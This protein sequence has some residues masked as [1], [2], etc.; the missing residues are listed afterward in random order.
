[1]PPLISLDPHQDQTSVTKCNLSTP[2]INNNQL[3]AIPGHN[4]RNNCI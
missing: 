3:A 1:M 2:K 4:I